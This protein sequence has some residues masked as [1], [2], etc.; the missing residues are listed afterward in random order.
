MACPSKITTQSLSCIF[1]LCP[2]KA[3]KSCMS[4]TEKQKTLRGWEK[5]GWKWKL[6]TNC[7]HTSKP[8]FWAQNKMRTSCLFRSVCCYLNY[9]IKPLVYL[10]GK[11]QQW[12][13]RIYFPENFWPK[14]CSYTHSFSFYWFPIIYFRS[15]IFHHTHSCSLSNLNPMTF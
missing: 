8:H 5:G 11:W 6:V 15:W 7:V 9:Q 12:K 3:E 1:K 4:N 10:L 14:E 2:G 13:T